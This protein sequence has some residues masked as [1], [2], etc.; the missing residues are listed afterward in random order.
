MR[1]PC[2]LTKRGC[3]VGTRRLRRSSRTTTSFLA[4]CPNLSLDQNDGVLLYGFNSPDHMAQTWESLRACSTFL[5]KGDKIKAARCFPVQSQDAGCAVHGII[6]ALDDHLHR[7]A[8]TVGLTTSTRH[9]WVRDW[10]ER[11]LPG[12]NPAAGDQNEEDGRRLEGAPGNER[13]VVAGCAEPPRGVQLSDW[14]IDK[15]RASKNNT[16]AYV[17]T[18]ILSCMSTRAMTVVIVHVSLPHG[19]S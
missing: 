1:H 13:A 19:L 5:T 17:L 11:S 10:V 2:R 14:D 15:Q 18:D 7:N 8:G 12:D 16:L 9:H 3:F 4:A 6:S